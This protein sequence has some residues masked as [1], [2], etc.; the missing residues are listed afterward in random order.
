LYVCLSFLC[1]TGEEALAEV[2]KEGGE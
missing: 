1:G 2:E